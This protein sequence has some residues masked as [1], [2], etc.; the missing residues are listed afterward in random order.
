MHLVSYLLELAV[1]CPGSLGCFLFFGP[2]MFL[3][4]YIYLFRG[5]TQPLLILTTFLN[6]GHPLYFCVFRGGSCPGSGLTGKA[7]SKSAVISPKRD[8]GAA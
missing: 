1:L 5:K 7:S 4:P 3:S 2:G 8:A 6:S